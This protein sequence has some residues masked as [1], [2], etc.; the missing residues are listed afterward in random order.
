MLHYQKT[1][2]KVMITML[3]SCVNIIATN[4]TAKNV[5]CMLLLD[6]EIFHLECTSMFCYSK[7]QTK[8]QHYPVTFNEDIFLTQHLRTVMLSHPSILR[9]SNPIILSLSSPPCY[10]FKG[11]PALCMQ[12]QCSTLMQQSRLQLCCR[13]DVPLSSSAGDGSYNI[14]AETQKMDK[15]KL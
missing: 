7:V 11:I 1:A 10:S 14:V 13:Y 2:H 4:A 3:Q 6:I 15:A 12:H 5:R 8:Q 9:S